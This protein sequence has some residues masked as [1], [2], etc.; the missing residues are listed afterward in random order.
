MFL[1]NNMIKFNILPVVVERGITSLVLFFFVFKWAVW[2]GEGPYFITYD[3]HMEE[4]GSLEIGLNPTVGSPSSANG[5]LSVLTEL[6]YGVKGWWTSELYLTGQSTRRDSMVFTGYRWENRFRPLTREHWINPVLYF[7]FEDVNGADKTLKEVVGHD[8][9]HDFLESNSE[10]RLEKER[11]FEIKG[12]LSSNFRGW[13]LAENFIAVKN[14]TNEPWEFGYALGIS[15]PLALTASPR[16]CT[17]C[18]ENFQVGLELYGGLGDWHSFG[19][20]ETSHYI[21]PTLSWQLPNG[22]T[23]P[24]SP[25]F[26]LT[27]P[28]IQ[29]LVRFSISHE[30]PRFGRQLSQWFH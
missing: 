2:A 7:E 12:I 11:E 9:E 26:G 14:I 20:H 24:L 6:E 4:P 16:E 13:N 10:A 27:G 8:S 18:R 28:S 3:H 21:A 17:L 30:I 1:K 22:T 19:F 23:V 29:S 15:R 5:F 25:T